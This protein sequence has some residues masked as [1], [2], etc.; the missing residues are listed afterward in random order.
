MQKKKK[1]KKIPRGLDD[2]T[3]KAQRLFQGLIFKIHASNCEVVIHRILHPSITRETV[4]KKIPS[5]AAFLCSF[6]ILPWDSQPWKAPRGLQ[7]ETSSR[8][9]RTTTHPL[10]PD[11]AIDLQSHLFQGQAMQ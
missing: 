2:L 7:K 8:R 3:H 6:A 4:S 9:L 1:K 10:P 5:H 11:A